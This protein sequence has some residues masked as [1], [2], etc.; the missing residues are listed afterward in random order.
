MAPRM[1]W[2]M[3]RMNGALNSRL[4]AHLLVVGAHRHERSTWLMLGN[5]W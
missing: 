4:Q 2:A 1:A 5:I 3:H